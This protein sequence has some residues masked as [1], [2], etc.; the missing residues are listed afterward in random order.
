[1]Q[2]VGYDAGAWARDDREPA[3]L[4]AADAADG[5]GGGDVER[6]PL[7]PGTELP[8]ALDRRQCAGTLDGTS[9]RACGNETAPYCGSHA[10]TWVCARCTGDCLKDEMDCFEDHAIYLAGFAPASF[11]VGVTRAWRLETRLREQGAD[12]AAHLRT[13]DDGRVARRV[14]ARIAK[15]VGDR[16]RVPTKVEG[17]GSALDEAAWHE[18]LGE[19]DPVET[20]DFEYGLD[21]RRAP[22]PETLA[23]GTVRG[24]KGRVLVLDSAGSTYAVDMR[25]LV[26]WVVGEGDRTRDLQSSLGAFG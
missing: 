21:L 8:Y 23:T 12:R 24:V 25:D 22:V 14:E 10:D 5:P 1:V 20:V 13:V 7:D 9:H 16:V 11:K 19:F 15:D 2:I 4:L 3:L 26:G 18:L 17:L 6:V